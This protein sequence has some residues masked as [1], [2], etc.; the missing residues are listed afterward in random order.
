MIALLVEALSAEAFAPFGDVIEARETHAFWVN[1]GQAQRFHDLA[2]VE[3]GVD[4]HTSVSIFR[5]ASSH[6][7]LALHQLERHPLGS[8]AFIP[9]GAHPFLV[10]VAA[11]TAADVPEWP[12]AFLSN[13]Q[14]GVNYRP[15]LWHHA[16]ITL[17]H[18]TD[19]LVIDRGGPSA[20][21]D[22]VQLT[23]GY[24]IDAALL[25]D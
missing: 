4:G 20:N 11:T 6:F 3:V 21:C 18:S 1:D 13:G 16:L 15:G 10:V 2:R 9:L 14:Q 17:D 24:M 5:S 25:A 8:Q 23:A 7:P 22:V 12:R 19:F